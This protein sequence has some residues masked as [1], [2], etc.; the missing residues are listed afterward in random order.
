VNTRAGGGQAL[1][2]QTTAC[3]SYDRGTGLLDVRAEQAALGHLLTSIA[4]QSG[5]RIELGAGVSGSATVVFAGLPL[6]EGVRR[7]AESGGIGNIAVEYTRTAGAGGVP[8]FSVNKVTILGNAPTAHAAAQRPPQPD[9]VAQERPEPA[10]PVHAVPFPPA[11][12]VRPASDPLRA[13]ARPMPARLV[14]AGG[15][16][17]SLLRAAQRQDVRA[18]ALLG[19]MGIRQAT[20]LLEHLAAGAPE[21]SAVRVAATEALHRLAAAGRAPQIRAKQSTP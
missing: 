15:D 12:P 11:K 3:V 21:G 1:Q 20:P 10:A 6:E 19:Q 14:A 5:L 8:V 16:A 9:R 18:I 13:T 2:G 4:E 17:G 7:I